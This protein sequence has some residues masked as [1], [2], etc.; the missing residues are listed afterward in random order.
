MLLSTSALYAA[1]VGERKRSD[2]WPWQVWR[3]PFG[4]A[5]LLCALA[6]LTR[7]AL[8]A[9]VPLI[10]VFV[11]VRSNGWRWMS[12]VA[13]ALVVALAVAPWLARN[14]RLC[15]Q[16]FGFAPQTALNR[17]VAPE[18]PSLDRSLDPELSGPR[19][20]RVLRAKLRET[21]VRLPDSLPAA[22]VIMAFFAASLFWRTERD[23]VNALRVCLLSAWVL[24]AAAGELW[25]SGPAAG[26]RALLPTM[27]VFGAAFFFFTI[28]KAEFMD[29]LWQT[30]LPA[31]FVLVMALP[32]AARILGPRAAIPYP[33]Y[34]PPFAGYVSGLLEPGELLC[35]DIPWATA[36]YGDRTSL[37]LPSSVDE[38]M[39]IQ[40][41]GRNISGV[42]LTT[43]TSR[44]AGA[45]GASDAAA[46]SWLPMFDGKVPAEVPF[47]HALRL[48]PGSRDQIFLTDRQRWKPM[49]PGR[50]VESGQDGVKIEARGQE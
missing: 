45:R 17:A 31:A 9:L 39:K 26:C 2:G 27:M 16:P 24:M 36:W 25:D 33:P 38:M 12:G 29:T 21:L 6:F 20:N 43:E 11:A 35:T 8:V 46:Q 37:L 41:S 40:R 4:L 18:S 28:E 10:A 5:A 30:V 32:A 1:A 23:E 22:G 13:F 47:T 14:V 7:Y 34:F 19:A 49:Q 50:M 48:P 15:G 3:A 44:I 42:Y